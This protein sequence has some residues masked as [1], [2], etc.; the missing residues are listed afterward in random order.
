LN[1]VWRAGGAWE[2][3]FVVW[4]F[5]GFVLAL[6]I[7]VSAR[8]WLD[9]PPGEWRRFALVAGAV[10]ATFPST[11]WAA[12]ENVSIIRRLAELGHEHPELARIK[13]EYLS[14]FGTNGG[15][16]AARQSGALCIF[17]YGLWLLV[18][19]W[20]L[21]SVGVRDLLIISLLDAVVVFGLMILATLLIRSDSF[22]EESRGYPIAKLAMELRK[23]GL[24]P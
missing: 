1:I 12:L 10:I 11:I 4:L 20:A 24:R 22:L 14:R 18:G 3:L 13:I 21:P 2:R 23:Q 17:L 19:T 15:N 7:G 5:G 8:I 9:N 16:P 6:T